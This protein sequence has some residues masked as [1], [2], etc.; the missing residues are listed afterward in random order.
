MARKP[1]RCGIPHPG[2]VLRLDV[3]P[4]TPAATPRPLSLLD[5]VDI[6]AGLA[7]HE[8]VARTVLTARAADRLGYGRFWISEHHS[9]VGLGSSSP[10]I[11]IA[12]IAAATQGIRVGAAG[13]MLPNHSPLKVAEWFK[14][15]EMLH[16]GRIDLGLG[17]APGT[18]QLTAFALRRSREALSADDFP[19]V[20]SDVISFVIESFEDL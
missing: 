6:P 7:A 20:S 18:D 12:H 17:R 8:A 13:I 4:T 16:P 14:T 19:Q 10:E 1:T 3:T 2:T 11:L 15:L 5:F 9:F